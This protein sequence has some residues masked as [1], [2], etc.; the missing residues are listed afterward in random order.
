[1]P[2]WI[3]WVGQV[4]ADKSYLF[5]D[6]AFLIFINFFLTFFK[7][8]S[9][10]SCF[11]GLINFV[12]PRINIVCGTKPFCETGMSTYKRQFKDRK[13]KLRGTLWENLPGL[14][15]SKIVFR[16][17]NTRRG[18]TMIELSKNNLRVLVG[19]RTGYCHLPITLYLRMCV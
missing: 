3:S 4:A 7:M 13:E 11:Y 19:P 6:L 1:M 5:V 8:I 14:T 18:R 15:P 10:L 16:N 17:F 12:C 9:L 2:R